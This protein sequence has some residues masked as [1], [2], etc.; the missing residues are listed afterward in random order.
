LLLDPAALNYT[1]NAILT[2]PVTWDFMK[3]FFNMLKDVKQNII[4]NIHP[5]SKKSINLFLDN[6]LQL[7]TV[8]E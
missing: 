1:L 2:Q 5:D 8:T 6:C 7:Q 4:T 3:E